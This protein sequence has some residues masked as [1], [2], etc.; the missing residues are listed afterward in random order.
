VTSIVCLDTWRSPA[1][2]YRRETRGRASIVTRWYP[3][4]YYQCYMQRG[5]EFY[6]ADR[7]LYITG[8]E[9]DG[10]VWMV[11]DPP[12]WWGMQTHAAAYR[13]HV[14]CAGLGLGLIVHALNASPAVER[15]TVV[16]R[17]RDVIDLV[18]PQ[19]PTEKLTIVEG[20]WEDV[21]PASLPPADGVLYD[22]F[23]SQNAI[24]LLGDAIDVAA[25]ALMRW[26]GGDDFVV[27]VH[28]FP[29]DLIA[30][31]ARSKAMAL[32]WSVHDAS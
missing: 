4:G 7:R 31:A 8:L 1:S 22:L 14:V 13:G 2:K 26:N 6:Q 23:V 19:L 21:D 15:I 10:K 17:E 18:G 25:E 32:A 28:G 11:D 16:E 30:R 24:Q 20:A 29:P 9:I 12:H 5:Y 3:P 27:R